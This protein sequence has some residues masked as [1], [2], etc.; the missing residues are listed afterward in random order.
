MLLNIRVSPINHLFHRVLRWE[1][2]RVE[3]KLF[4]LPYNRKEE[5]KIRPVLFM[6]KTLGKPPCFFSRGQS[7]MNS[8][9]K[10]RNAIFPRSIQDHSYNLRCQRTTFTLQ[11]ILSGWNYNDQAALVRW[12]WM[13]TYSCWVCGSPSTPLIAK[14]PKLPSSLTSMC[15]QSNQSCESW[16]ITINCWK[17]QCSGM[18]TPY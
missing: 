11:P 1:P 16:K 3:E 8:G 5:E 12:G 7:A 10:Q 14:L 6:C 4:F 18:Q 9:W 2:R 13:H 17:Y 15:V